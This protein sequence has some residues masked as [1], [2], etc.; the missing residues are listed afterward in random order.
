MKISDATK[1]RLEEEILAN[2]AKYFNLVNSFRSSVSM[3]D[4]AEDYISK[5]NISVP[6]SNPHLRRIS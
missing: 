5:E 4:R 6:D 3:L 1:K 2:T